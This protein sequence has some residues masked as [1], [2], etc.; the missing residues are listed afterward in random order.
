MFV[1]KALRINLVHDMVPNLNK[2]VAYIFEK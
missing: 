2:F 1:K